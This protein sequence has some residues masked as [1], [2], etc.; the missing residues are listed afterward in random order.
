MHRFSYSHNGIE[1]HSQDAVPKGEFDARLPRREDGIN[2]VEALEIAD[3]FLAKVFGGDFHPSVAGVGLFRQYSAK[4]GKYFWEWQVLY[5]DPDSEQNVR[6]SKL[7]TVIVSPKGEV[8]M[9]VVEP[10]GEG[11]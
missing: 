7:I 6:F 1:I 3:A 11:E 10:E 5:I 2:S 9:R 4:K 8:L